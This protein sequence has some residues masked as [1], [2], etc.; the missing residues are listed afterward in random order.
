[1][2]GLTS[3]IHKIKKFQHMTIKLV[4]DN[5]AGTCRYCGKSVYRNNDLFIDPFRPKSFYH[6]KCFRDLLKNHPLNFIKLD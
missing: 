4:V 3:Y 5:K 1:M 2:I 6:G